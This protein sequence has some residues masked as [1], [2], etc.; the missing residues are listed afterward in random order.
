MLRR[1]LGR[2]EAVCEMPEWRVP[3]DPGGLVDFFVGER[4]APTPLAFDKRLK[5]LKRLLQ[6]VGPK[7]QSQLL[8]RRLLHASGLARFPFSRNWDIAYGQVDVSRACPSYMTLV[9]QLIDELS[10]F[11]YRASWTGSAFAEEN[12]LGF[13]SPE[14]EN[15][16]QRLLGGF[17][18]SVVKEALA[19]QGKDFYLEKNTW[20]PLVFDHFH[21]L[22][23]EAKLVVI[24]REPK[25]VICSLIHQRWAPSDIEQATK[26][27]LQLE[28]RW[29]QVRDKVPQGS[30][31]EVVYEHLVREPDRV[32]DEISRFSKL[33][34]HQEPFQLSEK[35]IGRWKVDLSR[36]QIKLVDQ[37]LEGH[38]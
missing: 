3:V 4:Y 29:L 24:R 8:Y 15:G 6:A 34:L 5:D 2:H 25:D 18:R 16:F 10:A 20:Y 35:S 9:Q 31:I 19:N 14:V 26:Y 7:P 27:Y 32:L 11:H 30:F 28:N 12:S 37:L 17:F 1:M 38:A 13:P 23:P 36:E 22:V 33:P 21:E